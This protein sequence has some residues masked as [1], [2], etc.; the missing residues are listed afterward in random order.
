MPALAIAG[1]AILGAIRGSGNRITDVF[2]SEGRQNIRKDLQKNREERRNERTDRVSSI[3]NVGIRAQGKTTQVAS[4][5][6]LQAVIKVNDSQQGEIDDLRD[7]VESLRDALDGFAVMVLESAEKDEAIA[8]FLSSGV[9]S[10]LQAGVEVINA[11]DPV[12]NQ[13]ARL[14]AVGVDAFQDSDMG[15]KASPSQRNWMKAA[16][17]ALTMYAYYDGQ[18]LSSMW[19]KAT[20]ETTTTTTAAVDE[21]TIDPLDL[22]AA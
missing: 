17:A 20:T 8:G 13:G 21:L 16:E 11:D 15:Q 18:D 6:K 22:L 4:A 2:S 12:V 1:G 3:P 5:G 10:I 14:L 19:T 7:E 9:L